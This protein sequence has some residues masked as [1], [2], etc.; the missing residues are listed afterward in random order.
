VIG[1]GHPMRGDDGVGPAVLERLASSELAE[2]PD[3]ALVTLDGE[4]TRL[5]DAWEGAD[6]AVVVDAAVVEAA[7]DSVAGSSRPGTIEV[8]EVADERDVSAPGR[9]ASSHGLG[10][11]EAV[12]LGNVLGRLPGRLVLVTVTAGGVA[13]GDGLSPAVAR[14]VDEAAAAVIGVVD[15]T[16]PSGSKDP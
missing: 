16:S 7:M 5:L 9:A 8:V 2:R 13:L 3:V 15:G 6:L 11:V 12:R 14:A 10:V 4:A 1:V